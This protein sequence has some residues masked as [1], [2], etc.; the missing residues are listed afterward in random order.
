MLFWGQ[1]SEMV[2]KDLGCSIQNVLVDAFGFRFHDF[3]ITRWRL[4]DGTE[5]NSTLSS[6]GDRCQMFPQ[7]VA[8]KIAVEITPDRVDV[9]AVVLGVGCD[10]HPQIVNLA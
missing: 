4:S 1:L 10:V 7:Q 3:T 8:A 9:I 6:M 5:H 2:F